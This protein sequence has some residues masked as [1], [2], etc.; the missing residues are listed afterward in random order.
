MSSDVDLERKGG[1]TEPM[2]ALRRAAG[3]LLDGYV[4]RPL[5]SDWDYDATRK[6]VAKEVL[7]DVR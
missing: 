3:A 7:R 4:W 5:T 6:R 1:I 2:N